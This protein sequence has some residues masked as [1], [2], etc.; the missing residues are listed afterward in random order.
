[1]HSEFFHGVIVLKKAVDFVGF[2][3][4][5]TNL[6]TAIA[7]VTVFQFVAGFYMFNLII[8]RYK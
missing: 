4:N 7:V 5:N 1:M 6:Q 3:Q 2:L 8:K